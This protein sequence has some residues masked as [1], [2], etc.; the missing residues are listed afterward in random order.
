MA[1]FLGSEADGRSLLGPLHRLGASRDTFAS[2]PPVVLGDLA[3]DP[4]DP[5][6]FHIGHQL[7]D[8]LPAYED[9]RAGDVIMVKGSLGSRM[10]PLVEALRVKSS[11]AACA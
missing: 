7:L 10:A 5:L 9:I 2:V 8:A 11:D 3:M 6:P 1:A 4:L